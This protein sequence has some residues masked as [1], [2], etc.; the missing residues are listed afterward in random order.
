MAESPGGSKGGDVRWE[1]TRAERDEISGAGG[2]GILDLL[3]ALLARPRLIPRAL[4]LAASG[5]RQGIREDPELGWFLYTRRLKR[6]APEAAT[7]AGWYGEKGFMAALEPY[8]GP[9]ARAL[10]VG[11]GAGRM[12]R[13]VAPKVGEAVGCDVSQPML[14][15]A[16]KNLAGVE[17]VTLLRA[18]L[19]EL[20]KRGLAPFDVVFAHD[21][22]VN[23]DSDPAVA[24]LDRMREILR[25]GGACVASFLT[26]DEDSWARDHMEANRGLG[27][28]THLGVGHPRLYVSAQVDAMMRMAGFDL[29]EAKYGEE[30]PDRSRPHYIVVGRKPAAPADGS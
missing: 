7:G 19:G 5:A 23:I 21:V 14:D 16:A 17:N 22:F 20:Q 4:R 9:S 10:E 13:L 28:M 27:Q 11:C 18:D 26:V 6:L 30:G 1:L 12:L 15:E 8:L 3:R 24:M 25:P 29:V 2:F